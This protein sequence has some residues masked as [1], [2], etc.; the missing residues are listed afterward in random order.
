[1]KV[2]IGGDRLGAGKKNKVSLKGFNRSTHDLSYAWRSTMGSGTLVPFM[3]KVTLP[4]DTWDI[5]LNASVLTHPTIGPLF[6]SYKVQL[7]IFQI[8][9]R[10]YQG[11]LHNNKLNI[12]RNMNNVKLPLLEVYADSPDFTKGNVDNEQINP[13]CIL[14]YLGMRGVGYGESNPVGRRFNGLTYLMY[15]DIYKNYYAN[16]QEEI[17]AVIHNDMSYPMDVLKIEITTNGVTKLIEQSPIEPIVIEIDGNSTIK[18]TTVGDNEAPVDIIQLTVNGRDPKPITSAFEN[19]K[20][21]GAK[22]TSGT[23]K[24]GRASTFTTSGFIYEDTN[25]IV[26]SEP[27]VKTFPLEN[28]DTMREDILLASKDTGAF[29]INGTDIEPYNLPLLKTEAGRWSKLASQEGLAVKTYQSDLFNNWMSTEWIDGE[30]GVNA[31]TAIDTSEGSF[32]IDTLNLSRKVYDMLNRIAI[33]GGSYDD[34]VEVVYDH[35]VIRK[36]SSPVYAG[37][38]SKE[39][40]FQEVISNASS[41]AEGSEQPLGTLAGRGVMSGKH[42]GGKV[43]IKCDEIGYIMGI[44]S[45]TP[46]IDYSQ[47]NDWDTN[48]KT[49]DDFHKPDLDQIGF[50]DLTTDQLAWWDTEATTGDVQMKSAGKQPAWLNYMTSVNEVRGNFAI[51]GEQMFMTLNRRYEASEEGI[52]DLTTYIDP[53]K[54]NHIFADTSR[55]AQNFWVQIG[56]GATVRRKM[57]AKQIPNL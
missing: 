41:T 11:K 53:V 49:M 57:S 56:V 34:W 20:W 27:K 15:W 26:Q 32:T 36:I 14:S 24:L 3:H 47:G 9:A 18:I 31:V 2:T 46:R 16:K 28:I 48:L 50:Q 1:M 52:V 51:E 38:L 40:V 39:L 5:D 19:W 13:S 44:V 37:G 6:G 45:L 23:G 17:G 42:K 8:P 54:F 4:G 7:D 43:T 35:Q 29:I 25:G 33:S 21:N 12:G 22:I 10:L 55:D 30:N